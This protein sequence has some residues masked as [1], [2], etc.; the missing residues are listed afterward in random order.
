MDETIKL[1]LIALGCLL[2]LVVAVVL[3]CWLVP[4]VVEYIKQV[5]P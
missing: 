4:P 1:I 3:A 2:G 5:M